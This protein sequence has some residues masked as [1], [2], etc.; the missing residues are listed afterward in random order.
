[1]GILAQVEKRLV[2]PTA[3]LASHRAGWEYGGRGAGA[4]EHDPS[5]PGRSM[6]HSQRTTA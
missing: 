5:G 6:H 2:L 1:M 3:P 4:R